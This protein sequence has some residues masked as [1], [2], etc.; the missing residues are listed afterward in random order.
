MKAKKYKLALH[1][2]QDFTSEVVKILKAVR[3]HNK[4][5][6][7][8]IEKKSLAKLLN[9]CPTNNEESSTI[10]NL[11]RILVFGLFFDLFAYF[12]VKK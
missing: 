7:R 5:K 9:K 6:I 10:N 3:I 4:D 8:T 2:F 11:A 1:N 12:L